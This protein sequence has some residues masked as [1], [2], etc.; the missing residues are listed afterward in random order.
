MLT[1][2]IVCIIFS[3]FSRTKDV[4]VASFFF[5][6]HTHYF[7]ARTVVKPLLINYPRNS[8]DLQETAYFIPLL[9]APAR[10]T[11][12]FPSA[13]ILLLS[14]FDLDGVG[15]LKERSKYLI[16]CLRHVVRCISFVNHVLKVPWQADCQLSFLENIEKALLNAPN[17]H[18]SISAVSQPFRIPSSF[19]LY[20]LLWVFNS[21][22]CVPLQS[23]VH[24]HEWSIVR[25]QLL[26]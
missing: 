13:K 17:H 2:N 14:T 24:Q 26:L 1:N 5:L 18:I 21:H 8:M 16:K 6:E 25:K 10:N 23:K 4:G 15:G 12:F 22:C 9:T 3:F 19:S 20:S 11:R 7:S